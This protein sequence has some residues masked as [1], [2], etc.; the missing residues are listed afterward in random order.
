MK[1][2]MKSYLFSF[3]LLGILLV[4]SSII[5]TVLQINQVLSYSN[6]FIPTLVISLLIFWIVGIF[7]GLKVA[8]KGLVVGFIFALIY[9]TVVY[10]Y[11][12]LGLDK[13]MTLQSHLNYL[14]RSLMVIVGAVMGVNLRK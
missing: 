12:Y 13:S 5:I 10:G 2:G 1:T 3:I 11:N 7:L 4:I 8:R 6:K 9:A 14:G